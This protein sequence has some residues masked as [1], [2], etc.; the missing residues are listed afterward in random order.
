MLKTALLKAPKLAH[1]MTGEGDVFILDTDASAFALGGAL[2]Q[3]INGKEIPIGFA[4]KTLSRS[5]RNYCTTYREL[6]AVVEMIQRF[7]HYLWGRKFLLRTDHSS[8]RWLKNY[9]DA[10][11]MLARWLAKLQMYDFVIEHRAGKLHGNA[12]GLS[13]CHSCKNE[14]CKGRIVIPVTDAETSSYE[15]PVRRTIGTNTYSSKS[16][17]STLLEADSTLPVLSPKKMSYR[18]S[19]RVRTIDARISQQKWLSDFSQADIAATQKID[20]SVGKVYEWV[21][22]GERP[23]CTEIAKYGEEVKTLAS[24]WKQLSI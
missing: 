20:V 8:L 13:R 19:A 23:P 9:S 21:I 22:A 10:D 17:E 7:R 2:S 1:P 16:A 5:Q 24:R 4:S 6:L 3:R 12:D 14:D 11:G 15:F 18:Q